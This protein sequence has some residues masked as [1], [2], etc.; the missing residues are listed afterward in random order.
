MIWSVYCDWTA[1][2]SCRWLLHM[3]CP[4]KSSLCVF[5]CISV[6]FSVSLVVHIL[7]SCLSLSLSL[8]GQMAA[9]KL[10]SWNSA[11][12]SHYLPILV[13]LLATEKTARELQKSCHYQSHFLP[14]KNC[15]RIAEILLN[16]ALRG[17]D[18]RWCSNLKCTTGSTDFAL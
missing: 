8:S 15:N 5:A 12:V 14:L 16:R 10:S 2:L 1:Q 11:L 17:K 13:S 9:A 4:W 18:Q 6:S 7:G 3:L